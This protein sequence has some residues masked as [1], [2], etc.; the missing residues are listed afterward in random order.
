MILQQGIPFMYYLSALG[1][2]LGS[3]VM[4]IST[5]PIAPNLVKKRI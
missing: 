2:V 4:S 3:Q 5:S 1:N